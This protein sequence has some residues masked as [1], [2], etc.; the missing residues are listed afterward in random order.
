M[1]LPAPVKTAVRERAAD[2]CEYCR[3]RHRWEPL[4]V[5]HVEHVVARQHRGE[6]TLS[7]LAFACPQCNLNKGPNLSSRDPDSD[8]VVLLF[9]P[10]QQRWEDHFEMREGRISGK[11][12]TSRTTVFLL[13][14]NA[15]H[16]VELRSENLDEW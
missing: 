15:D 7:N 1:S 6:D 14:M 8:E 16:R 13:D 5:Y 10:R 2:R 3:M 9:H 11:T 12:G 4:N